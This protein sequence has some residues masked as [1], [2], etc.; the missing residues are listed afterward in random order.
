MIFFLKI[1]F[2]KVDLNWKDCGSDRDD[3][4]FSRVA[5]EL[6]E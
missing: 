3:D 5:P 2:V 6:N 4:E 1:G